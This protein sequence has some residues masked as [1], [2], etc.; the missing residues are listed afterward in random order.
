MRQMILFLALVAVMAP[1][2][3]FAD[4]ATP[5]PASTANTSCKAK[6]QSMGAATFK[7]TYRTFGKCVSQSVAQGRQDVSNAATTCKAQQADP[8]FAGAHGGKTFDQYYGSNSSK[9]NGADK[10]AYGKCVSQQVQ[11]SVQ[12]ETAAAAAA[13]KTCKAALKAD[14]KAFASKYG[15]TRNAFGKCVSQASKNK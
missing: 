5:T 4:S 3:A 15:A 11:Q 10:N 12:N 6:L 1:T 2:A 7:Q 8:S 9:G 13:A 14:A